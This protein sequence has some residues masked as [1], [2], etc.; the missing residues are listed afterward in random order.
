MEMT[1]TRAL[2]EVKLIEKKI[3]KYSTPNA[4]W[5]AVSKNGKIG[6]SDVDTLTK[7]VKENKQSVSDLISR[8]N[9][10]KHK[11]ITANNEATLTVASQTM[12]IAEAIDLKNFINI[13][14]DIYR[15]IKIHINDTEREYERKKQD[16]DN[17][18][19]R[20]VAQSLQSDGK[21]DANL[22]S[23][24]EKYVRDNNKIALEDPANI[25]E[26]VDKKLEYVDEFIS[27]IDFCLSEI[28]AITKIEV[29]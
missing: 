27:E 6:N 17:L 29:D 5:V 24:I 3:N 18:V 10:I 4:T 28:N 12:T 16:V 2:N 13:E 14:R 19:E 20:T 8:R 26:W 9:R 11:I 21:K 22:I 1:L 25:R 23:G 7:I 15:T